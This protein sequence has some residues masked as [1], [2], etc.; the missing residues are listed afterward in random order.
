MDQYLETVLWATGTLAFIV[1]AS[2]GLG[3]L[4]R[5]IA[6][7]GGASLRKQ[8]NTFA[9]FAFAAP[10]IIGFFIFVLAPMVASLYWSFTRYQLPKPPIFHGF[11]NYIRLLTTDKDF[12]ASLV[13][14]LYLT[15]IGLPAQ[16]IVA[17]GIAVLLNTRVK[18]LRIFRVAFY[19]PV[20]L[21]LNAAVLL[22]W[23]LM[24]NANNGLINTLLRS[25][26]A[27]FPPFNW[28]MRAGIYAVEV[29]NA[30]FLGLQ[31]GQYVLLEKTI[32]AGFPAI[33]R[34]PLWLQ[35]P[36]WTKTSIV[37]LMVWSCGTMM[38]IFL[39]ALTNVPK[40]FYEAAD[41]DGATG[42]Q[43]F[44]LITLPMISP[45][46]FYNLIVGTIAAIQIF[47]QPYIL[48]RDS[49][50]VAQSAYSVVY[51]LWRATFRFNEIGYGAAISWILLVVILVITLIQFKFQ[52]R[53][54]QYDLR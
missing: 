12:L 30:F 35:S 46:T 48:L 34:V 40:E 14:S 24:M 13:N 36:L 10:W 18:G 33:E 44:R 9:G 8:Q 25:V 23:R 32:A 50:T 19:M 11:E 26:G 4:A 22:C 7:M 21:G 42:W 43:K 39:A 52:D 45:S 31:N 54:V 3:S 53:W 5:A 38:M 51:Y 15:V 6:K 37:L 2:L 1:V 17:L 41:V 27:A 20:I 28:L 29:I 49:P 16:I 47:E